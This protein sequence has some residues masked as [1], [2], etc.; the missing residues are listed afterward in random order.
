MLVRHTWYISGC[1][2][3]ESVYEASMVIVG[4]PLS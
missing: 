4:S 1:W 2:G 3:I